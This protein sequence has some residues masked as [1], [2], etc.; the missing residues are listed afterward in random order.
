MSKWLNLTP[1]GPLVDYSCYRRVE[2]QTI[3]H[4]QKLMMAIT[5]D[6]KF[7]VHLALGISQNWI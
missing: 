1:S 6:H 7:L 5:D 4:S 3:D 2:N